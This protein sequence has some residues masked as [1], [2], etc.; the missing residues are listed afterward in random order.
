MS[1]QLFY[2]RTMITHLDELGVLG[3]A[4]SLIHG[5][6][7]RPDDVA[8]LA[9]AG[10]TIQHNPVSNLRLGSGLAPVRALLEAG[11][12][13]S[14]GSDGCGSCTASGMLDVVGATAMLHT[15]RGDPSDWVSAREAWAMATHYGARALG[16]DDLGRV[17][18]GQRA[19]LVCYR[20]DGP[21]FTPLNDP[22]RQLV[23]GE[24]GRSIDTMV[25]D[26]RLV[27]RGGHVTTVDEPSLLAAARQAHTALL[28]DLARSDALVDRIRPTYERI[29]RRCLPCA[30]PPDTYPSRF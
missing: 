20:L 4:L 28:S 13:V 26:G 10:S 14:L 17:G 16:L 5:V 12:N 23:C 6:W 19:D 29:Y 22:L 8:R 9:R 3:P 30:I 24:R 15:L 25:I 11:V 21:A 7:L 2:G 1:S 27:M 18:P